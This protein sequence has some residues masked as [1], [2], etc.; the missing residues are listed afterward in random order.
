MDSS[1]LSTS[2]MLRFTPNAFPIDITLHWYQM[3]KS[4]GKEKGAKRQRLISYYSVKELTLMLFWTLAL[5][6][7]FLAFLSSVKMSNPKFLSEG[8]ELHIVLNSK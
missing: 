5:L 2:C 1:A 8:R 6:C 4:R 7:G 3:N